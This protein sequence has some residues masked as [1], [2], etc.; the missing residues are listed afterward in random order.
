MPGP[1][2]LVIPTD[3]ARCH[4]NEI[5]Q[6]LSDLEDD[7]SVPDADVYCARAAMAV[8]EALGVD[9]AAPRQTSLSPAPPHPAD[10]DRVLP[11]MD[12]YVEATLTVRASTVIR[13]YSHRATSR[14][15]VRSAM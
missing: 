5:T 10:G 12:D 7:E 6:G 2:P 3:L 9:R 1:R 8:A 13:R 11:P 15:P 4:P 14:R